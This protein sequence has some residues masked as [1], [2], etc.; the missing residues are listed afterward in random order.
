MAQ[1]DAA[2]SWDD[3]A[4][5]YAQLDHFVEDLPPTLEI[6]LGEGPGR[7][8]DVG[9]GE[10]FLLDRVRRQHPEWSTTGLEISEVRADI[11]RGKGHHVV[12][13]EISKAVA[14]EQF[15]VVTCCHVIEHVPD[16][17]SFAQELA[18]LVRPGGYLYIETPLKLSGAW[19]FRRNEK[20]GWVLDPTHVREYRSAFEANEPLLNTGLTIRDLRAA[21]VLLALASAETLVRRALGRRPRADS[22][23]PTGWR[24]RHIAWPRYRVHHV[25]LKKDTGAAA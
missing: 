2:A 6:A 10:G 8:L 15:D 19:Y 11:A 16:D 18:A 14:G 25:L 20:A 5:E 1:D 17:W 23:R 3:Y 4:T 22:N 12:T 13:G 21:P 9:C 24:A 7:L